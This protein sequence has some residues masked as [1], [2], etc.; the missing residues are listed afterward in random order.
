[1]ARAFHGRLGK[2]FRLWCG[3][4][5]TGTE[6]FRRHRLPF[7]GIGPLR[8][9]AVCFLAAVRV[10]LDRKTV[11]YTRDVAVAY[12]AVKLGGRAVYE[13]HKEPIGRAAKWL[14]RRL[15]PSERFRLVVISGA[16]GDFYASR[17]AIPGSRLLVAH[18]G[19]W[20]EEYRSLRSVPKEELR[21]QL[22]LPASG[23]LVVHTGSLYRGRGAELFGSVAECGGDIVFLQIGGE[24]QDIDRWKSHYRALGIDNIRFIDR[25]PAGMVRKYQVAA[26]LLFYMITEDTPTYW[27]CS[28]LK[29]FEYMSS[30]TPILG[31]V[32]GSIGEVLDE[33]RAYC[34][35]PARP[36]D[37]RRAF[38]DFRRDGMASAGR[39]ERAL[40][41]VGVYVDA[42]R[43]VRAR[44]PDVEFALLGF[45]DERGSDAVSREQMDEWSREGVISY[46][47]EAEDVRPV[48]ADA[49]CVVLPS[50]YREGVP[51]SLL[52]AAAMSRPVI[53]TDTAGCREVVDDGVSG[54]LCRP[55]DA[56]DLGEKMMRMVGHSHQELLAMGKAGRN[57]VARSF[58]EEIVIDSYIHEMRSAG[59]WRRVH[60]RGRRVFPVRVAFFAWFPPFRRALFTIF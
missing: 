53:T 18:S 19:A 45:I 21:R 28:P 39:A 14:L 59:S 48:I 6:P 35:D 4:S 51:R 60:D 8:Y 5:P 16:L 33:K 10:A 46:L 20:P 37:I 15:V 3:G 12:T 56:G 36:D 25:Q 27:C 47:G 24:P 50:F 58:S 11:V 22:G 29:L 49:D 54:Y 26:D 40:E 55:G 13:A 43:M 57:K 32:I 38:G 52:E 7:G 23:L 1:M 42:A 34:F 2:D 30:G 9:P 44:F 31:A 41:A 17:Y